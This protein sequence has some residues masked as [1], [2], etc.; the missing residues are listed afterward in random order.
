MA[1]A[2]CNFVTAALADKQDKLTD[3]NGDALA[4]DTPVAT[5]AQ[6][7]EAVA[8][9]EAVLTT[10]QGQLKSCA[11]TDHPAGATVPTCDEMNTAI[12]AGV[13]SATI[14]DATDTVKGKVE[15]A[16]TAEAEAGTST[17][18]AVTPAGVAAA[19]AAIPQAT[20]TVVGKTRYATNA[21]TVAGTSAT[22]AVHPQ[23]MKYTLSTGQNY[24]INIA[25]DRNAASLS[26]A[27]TAGYFKNTSTSTTQAKHGVLG[28]VV[29]GNVA[30]ALTGEISSGTASGSQKDW[31]SA[32]AGYIGGNVTTTTL[33]TAVYA[34]NSS[35]A[36]LGS[37]VK[38]GV[39]GEAFGATAGTHIGVYGAASG[40]ATNWAGYFQ[41]SV[42]YSDSLT[43]SD[44]RLKSDFKPAPKLGSLK[45][46]GFEKFYITEDADGKEVRNS[47]GR[48]VGIIAQDLQ[49]LAP[50][51]VDEVGGYLA[52]KESSVLFA[53]IAELQ[54]EVAALKAK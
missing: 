4:A 51:L 41:G 32:V 22:A 5:C 17:T 7:E 27:A 52:V 31:N 50:E 46:Q 23:D 47:V 12:A 18:L 21:E 30:Q 43:P 33:S 14:P 11:G 3:C 13:A 1:F 35:I 20:E 28:S 24:P 42:F 25:A 44:K 19:I 53:L 6:V 9:V 29:A 48:Q 34:G 38:Y 45:I 37:A 16:T 2:S 26:A 36:T 49:K 39:Y 54:A 40:G 10:K 15:L 8:A